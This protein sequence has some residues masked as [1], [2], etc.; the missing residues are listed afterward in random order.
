MRDYE[1]E[2]WAPDFDDVKLDTMIMFE[3]ARAT[4]LWTYQFGVDDVMKRMVEGDLMRV[5]KLSGRPREATIE[6]LRTMK[7]F[8]IRVDA[9][10]EW[11]DKEYVTILPG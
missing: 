1:V 11:H 10:L 9:L 8:T 5:V 4:S 7:T 3:R 2:T 6:E